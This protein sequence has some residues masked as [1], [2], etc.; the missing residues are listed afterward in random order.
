MI[1]KVEMVTMDISSIWVL[2]FVRRIEYIKYSYLAHT[3]EIIDYSF[4]VEDFQSEDRV[5]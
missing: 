5:L 3:L 1:P 2:H 4:G